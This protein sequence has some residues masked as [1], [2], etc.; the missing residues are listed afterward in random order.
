ML[1]S[2][3]LAIG[4]V[5]MIAWLPEY[6]VCQLIRMFC[7]F[8]ILDHLVSDSLWSLCKQCYRAHLLSFRVSIMETVMKILL[9][10]QL[11]IKPWTFRLK[12]TFMKENILSMLLW[13]LAMRLN[14]SFTNPLVFENIFLISSWHLPMIFFPLICFTLVNHSPE[15]NN[16]WVLRVLL[17]ILKLKNDL[18]TL[19]NHFTHTSRILAMPICCCI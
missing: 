18:E 19:I 4:P 15:Y 11:Q 8:T 6:P 12:G 9:L 3:I 1:K 10:D 2:W 13:C 7:T 17:V 14:M 5:C 16:S